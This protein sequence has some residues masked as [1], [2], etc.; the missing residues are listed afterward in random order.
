L[1]IKSKQRFF[2]NKIVNNQLIF[3]K[4]EQIADI[5]PKVNKQPILAR[6]L[7]IKFLNKIEFL[8]L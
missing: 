4:S 8:E 7:K 1:F 3:V 5:L 2:E 6:K